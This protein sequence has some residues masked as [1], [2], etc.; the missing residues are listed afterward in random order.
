MNPRRNFL[1]SNLPLIFAAA[2]FTLAGN[3]VAKD[4]FGGG[5]LAFNG[6]C[7]DPAAVAASAPSP[8]DRI[9]KAAGEAASDKN[10]RQF[11]AVSL[12]EVSA[13]AERKDNGCSA[14][15]DGVWKEQGRV[16]FDASVAPQG[17]AAENPALASFAHGD[18]TT[19]NYFIIDAPQNPD[20]IL[21]LHEVWG[22]ATA[23]VF[24][25]TDRTSIASVIDD[26]E[27]NKIY[28][29]KNSD[30]SDRQLKLSRTHSG[31][32]RFTLDGKDYYRPVTGLS[33]NTR[34]GQ[35]DATD[36]F[37]LGYNPKNLRASRQGYDPVTQ[38]PDQFMQNGGKLDIFERAAP[39][40]YEIREQLTVPIGLTLIEEGGQAYVY[41]SSLI[42]SE[43]DSQKAT[44][45]SFGVKAEVRQAKTNV[46]AGGSLG[47][48]HAQSEIEGL[49]NS[50]SISKIDAYQRF[51]KY[52]LVRDMAYSRLSREF[53]DALM[54]ARSN[55]NAD[56][57]YDF[58]R[59]F[60]AF[61]T[62]YPY[63]VT[64]GAAGKLSTNITEDTLTRNF[65]S[66]TRDSGTASISVNQGTVSG[67]ISSSLRNLQGN[68]A[69]TNL[70]VTTFTAVGGN[71]S[72]NESGFAAGDTPYPI[73]MDL[74]P[75][76]DLLN[77]INFPD[78]PEIYTTMREELAS[79]IVAY[80]AP[81]AEKLGRTSLLANYE[82]KETWTITAL[83]IACY[84]PG[85]NE[86][87]N[88][89]ELKGKANYD[90][91]ANARGAGAP[92]WKRILD[93][94]ENSPLSIGCNG[95]Y[96]TLNSRWKSPAQISYEA[97]LQASASTCGSST[98]TLL[99]PTT[100]LAAAL[101]LQFLQV[102][103]QWVAEPA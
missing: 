86:N 14:R 42:A 67:N 91:R 24:T 52:A 13:D 68:S 101:C 69:T 18:Y 33:R 78:D 16:T 41:Y 48:S 5:A 60:N 22:D 4:Q 73:L 84:N 2:T 20:A 54:D 40:D 76:S 11:S 61:G 59:I 74:R 28:I 103:I 63:A 50:H 15:L 53:V 71:G 29:A 57:Q 19:P 46:G 34:E 93:Y 85:S 12:P 51:K 99:N 38:N 30:G 55:R 23:V 6:D 49:K 88:T 102:I 39:K 56:G 58:T 83:N 36:P 37:V 98:T 100:R 79:A 97:S 92:A 66:F 21:T 81:F 25:S 62:H 7:S 8:R 95:G 31:L 9:L 89:V 82:P 47:Y 87:D 35:S 45:S 75:I 43:E 26:P 70:G 64:Y 77:P 1:T 90:T 72:W 94:P 80:E 44:Q 17:W 10:N 32:V 3:A 96:Q 65:E 27:K